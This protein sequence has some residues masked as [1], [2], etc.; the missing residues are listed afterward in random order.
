MSV[1]CLGDLLFIVS[2]RTRLSGPRRDDG[3]TVELIPVRHDFA[4]VERLPAA[5]AIDAAVTEK[6]DRSRGFASLRD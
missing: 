5:R 3:F 1:R 2:F 4:Q 6:R